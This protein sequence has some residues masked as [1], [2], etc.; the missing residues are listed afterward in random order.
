MW[1]WIV[2]HID[3]AVEQI[4]VAVDSLEATWTASN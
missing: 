1:L 3:V 4:D 2:E